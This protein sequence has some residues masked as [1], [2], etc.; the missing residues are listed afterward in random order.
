[1]KILFDLRIAQ[2]QA[3]RGI[4][5]YLEALVLELIKRKIDISFLISHKLP[6]PPFLFELKNHK[7]Y[8]LEN[9][10]NYDISEDF[11]FF[12]SGC[13]TMFHPLC[14]SACDIIDVALPPNVIQ[15]CHRNVGIFYD[16]IPLMLPEIFAPTEQL[17]NIYDIT[18]KTFLFADHLF[19]ISD[20]AKKQCI[21]NIKR[22]EKDITVIHSGYN[23]DYIKEKTK[24]LDYT[25]K[26]RFDLVDISG[27]APTKNYV[28]LTKEFARAYHNRKIPKQARLFLIC[29]CS[30]TY[31]QAVKK[32]AETFGL[33]VGKQVIVTDY[34]PYDELISIVSHSKALLHPSLIEGSGGMALEA[35]ACKVPGFIA[36][37]ELAKGYMPEEEL[38]SSSNEGIYKTIIKIYNDN[39]CCQKVFNYQKKLQS[40]FSPKTAATE[41]LEKLETLN[42]QKK[43]KK[44]ASIDAGTGAISEYTVRIHANMH[45]KFDIFADVKNFDELTH[46]H[47][48]HPNANLC[49][50]PL[51]SFNDVKKIVDYERKIFVLGNSQHHKK[52]FELACQTK[53]EENRWII[54]HEPIILGAYFHKFD[55]DYYRLF[56]EFIVKWYPKCS[57]TN[58]ETLPIPFNK[59][60]LDNKIYLIRPLLNLTGIK[61]IICY[62]D[63]NK[64]TLLSELSEDEKKDLSVFSIPLPI[65]KFTNIPNTSDLI[66]KKSK[67]LIGSF[68]IP[69]NFYKRTNL[70]IDATTILNEKYHYDVHLLIAGATASSYADKIP[71]ITIL[72]NP[73]SDK[74][75]P[76]LN[77]VDLGIQLR[78]NAF[79]F[80]SA[81]IVELLGLGKKILCTEGMVNSDWSGTTTSFPE[82][83]EAEDLAL[84]IIDAL[85]KKPHIPENIIYQ[86]YSF[87]ANAEKIY[88]LIKEER[89]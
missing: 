66:E 14:E 10:D 81:T 76:L 71:Y 31:K 35:A 65:Q 19:A 28:N 48:L 40:F 41:I 67:Y 73:P 51:T 87:L 86:K 1:M 22:P 46:L 29:K 59:F 25:P 62:S 21:D 9:F 70:I 5:K 17:K 72:S 32:A 23:Y 61:N 13:Y 12:F 60:Y 18:Y 83:K 20:Y 11:D 45:E 53:G 84:Y 55:N 34:I 85:K 7:Q 49:V 39:E 58:V 3:H 47:S 43:P 42:Q 79:S 78:E 89:Q 68:G 57:E 27:D 16:A 24:G 38:F 33:E 4:G 36:G 26:N 50:L 77:T 56:N 37:T 82:G 75:L 54:L 69:D 6:S 63:K 80:S 15:R 2:T 74:W 30:E 88:N 8:I 64:E 44:I 52:I